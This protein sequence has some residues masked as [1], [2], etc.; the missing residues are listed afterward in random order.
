M[1]DNPHSLKLEFLPLASLRHTTNQDQS[2]PVEAAQMGR[3]GH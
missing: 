2:D 1:I 3:A